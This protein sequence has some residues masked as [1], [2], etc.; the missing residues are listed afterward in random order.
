MI[1]TGKKVTGWT[2][3]DRRMLRRGIGRLAVVGTLVTIAACG[4]GSTA[5]KGPSPN[6][7]AAGRFALQSVNTQPLPFNLFNETGFK[8][9]FTAA[10]LVLQADGKY[11]MAQTTV[12]TV[13]GFA[14]TYQ[15]TL[16][17]T[18]TQS[19]GSLSIRGEDSTVTAATWDGRDIQLSLNSEGQTLRTV[20][21]KAP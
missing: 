4:D 9:D 6:D 19:A 10:S 16:R 5:P 2:R 7:P 17:G 3:D 1:A 20:F 15:D 18:W 13:A 11:V 12:E 8:L 14:S 21:R